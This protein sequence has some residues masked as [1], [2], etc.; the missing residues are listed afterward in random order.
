LPQVDEARDVLAN[1]VLCHV[2]VVRYN[3]SSKVLY[4]AVMIG[5]GLVS[6]LLASAS[7]STPGSN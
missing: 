3:F 6:C 4:T 1:V 2:P 7:V 5:S